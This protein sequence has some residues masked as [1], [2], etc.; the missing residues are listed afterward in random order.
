MFKRINKKNIFHKVKD[1]FFPSIGIKRSLVYNKHR[2]GRM[3]ASSYAIAA[4]FACG[5]AVSFTPFI[6]LHFVMSAIFAYIM[7]ASI[8]SS[9]FGTIVGNPWTFPFIWYATFETGI[10]I[11]GQFTSYHSDISLNEVINNVINIFSHMNQY[12]FSLLFGG[13]NIGF[14]SYIELWSKLFG[15]IYPMVIGSVI[16]VVVV[17]VIFYKFIKNIV[18]GYRA[19]NEKNI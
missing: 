4:G 5:A 15:Y 3:N 1:F 13:E 7:R 19:K 8:I 12:Y 16:Y 11:L 17:W 18:D 14:K 10:F 2:L 6:G 9:A